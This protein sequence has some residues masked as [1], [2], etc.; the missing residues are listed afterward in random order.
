MI[1]VK[2]ENGETWVNNMPVADLE[3]LCYIPTS[4]WELQESNKQPKQKCV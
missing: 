3:S 2:T 1:I 4:G